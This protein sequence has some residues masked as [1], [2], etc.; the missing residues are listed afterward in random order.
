MISLFTNLPLAKT[1]DIIL[2]RVYSEKLV[3]TNLTKRTMKKLLKDAC[4]K[5]AFTFNDKIYKQ[6]DSVSMGSPLGPLLP[7]V[8][9]TEL[10]KDIIQKLIDKNFI[11]FCIPYVDDTVLL[12]KDE[13][14]DPILKELNSYNKNIKFTADRFINED[15]HILNIKIHHQN[16]TDIYYKDTHTGQYINYGSERP[17]KLKTSW[18][19]ALHHCAHKICSNKQALDKQISHI[20]TFMSWDGYPKRVRISTQITLKISR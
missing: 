4:S 12:V 5:I 1:I 14:I 7:N 10:D 6:I 8:F 16:N 17:W 9:M 11:K 19:K 2:K 3:T 13:N 15:V 20:K 18:I